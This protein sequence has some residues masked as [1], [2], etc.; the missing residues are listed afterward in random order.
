MCSLLKLDE[1]KET[2]THDIEQKGKLKKETLNPT[3]VSLNTVTF[4]VY[5]GHY[6]ATS[7]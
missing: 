3:L 5:F 2:F 7:T 4:F 1:V 6:H